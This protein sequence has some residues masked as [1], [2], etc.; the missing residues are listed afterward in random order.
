MKSS[1]I[2]SII[3][4]E[5]YQGDCLLQKNYIAE[6][7]KQRINRDKKSSTMFEITIPA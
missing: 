2:I 1:R 5:K 4:N 7:G 6:D 3:S